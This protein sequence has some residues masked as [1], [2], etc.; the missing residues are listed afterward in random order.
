MKIIIYLPIFFLFIFSSCHKIIHNDLSNKEDNGNYFPILGSLQSTDIHYVYPPENSRL[1][2]IKNIIEEGSNVKIGDFIAEFTSQNSSEDMLEKKR[3]L[4]N[5]LQEREKYIQDTT[6]QIQKNMNEINKNLSDIEIYNKTVAKQSIN[7]LAEFIPLNTLK[8][9]S[10]DNKIK[11]ENLKNLKIQNN[12][13]SEKLMN[14]K[15]FYSTRIN[16]LQKNQNSQEKSYIVK[17]KANGII[18]FL[19]N[20]LGEKFTTGA[21]AYNEIPIARIENIEKMQVLSYLPEEQRK[22]AHIGLNVKIIIF[23]S[24]NLE[25]EGK[26]QSISK[27]VMPL[28]NWDINL[29]QSKPS[30]IDPLFFQ[31]IVSLNSTSLKPATKVQVL[32]NKEVN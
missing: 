14:Y 2:S 6:S 1:T 32:L 5:L 3:K 27:I 12:F 30:S 29:D 22:L 7:E 15:N 23:G 31:L 4:D 24:Q 10:L 16:I 26:I 17:S 11:T 19:K 28:K 8:K 9:D 25:V 18:F 13:L 21:T 20:W